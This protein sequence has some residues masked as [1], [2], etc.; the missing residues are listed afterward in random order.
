MP[1][2]GYRPPVTVESVSSYLHTPVAKFEPWEVEDRYQHAPIEISL[3]RQ[4][5]KEPA[6]DGTEQS[7]GRFLDR[8]QAD[9]ML[10]PPTVLDVD[11]R[12]IREQDKLREDK[13]A[14]NTIGIALLTQTRLEDAPR[15]LRAKTASAAVEPFA[16][17]A[18]AA[19]NAQSPAGG[20]CLPTSSNPPEPSSQVP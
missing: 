3:E 4:A 7:L 17:A 2:L 8:R 16:V 9:P 18:T 20:L 11:Y 6:D 10:A 14:V 19:G 12:G 13:R 1:S 15:S 5:I